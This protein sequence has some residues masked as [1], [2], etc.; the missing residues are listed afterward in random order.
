[1][2]WSRSRT[3]AVGGLAAGALAALA[4]VL[5][6]LSAPAPG[7]AVAKAATATIRTRTVQFRDARVVVQARPHHLTCFLVSKRGCLKRFR[8]DQIGFAVSDTGV[9]GI[10]GANVRAVIV[11]LTRHGTVWATMHD[12][13][14]YAAI[15]GGY[16]ARRVV[17]VLKDGSR[18]SFN[19]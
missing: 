15:P 14:F 7:V 10:A 9:G 17:K 8:A 18:R 5:A 2:R 1:M 13:A 12:G 6:A 19:A 4:A 11:R 3:L 16:V